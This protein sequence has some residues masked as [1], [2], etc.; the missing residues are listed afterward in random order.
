MPVVVPL[1]PPAPV[2][3][4]TVPDDPVTVLLPVPAVSPVPV[5]EVPEPLLV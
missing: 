1:A 5:P 4:V 2:V 3:P